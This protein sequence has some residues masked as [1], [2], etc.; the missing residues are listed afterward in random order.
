[1]IIFGA[2]VVVVALVV[3]VVV[4]DVVVVLV[5]VLLVVENDDVVFS[6]RARSIFIKLSRP[7]GFSSAPLAINPFSMSFNVSGVNSL[8]T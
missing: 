3:V 4:V 6:L 1:M 8:N 2:F 7:F 5:V